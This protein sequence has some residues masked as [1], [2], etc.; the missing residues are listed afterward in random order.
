MKKRKIL[1]RTA[2]AL[3]SAAVIAGGAIVLDT[4]MAFAEEKSEVIEIGYTDY[5]NISY[6]DNNNGDKNNNDNEDI[7]YDVYTHEI[8]W[9]GRQIWMMEED[10]RSEESD[11]N[12][13]FAIEKAI[14]HIK[15]IAGVD[16]TDT[17]I[18]IGLSL[19]VIDKN[20]IRYG[21]VEPSRLYSIYFDFAEDGTDDMYSVIMNAI[22]GQIVCYTFWD[23]N[24]SSENGQID[25]DELNNY[26][27]ETYIKVAT[28]F[29]QDKLLCGQAEAL[30]TVVCT[31]TTANNGERYRIGVICSTANGE[32]IQVLVDYVDKNVCGYD[33]N[34]DYGY[35]QLLPD[36]NEYD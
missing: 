20:D 1:E 34:P 17:Y 8:T 28:D 27:E 11:I 12:P 29:L 7:E 2:I 5:D 23:K 21:T 9:N 25:E 35:E 19:Q 3:A 22:T 14:S 36:Y 4:R 13:G 6:D 30:D 26:D 15:E 24:P 32:I 18:Q 31:F 10:I 33:F 16:V